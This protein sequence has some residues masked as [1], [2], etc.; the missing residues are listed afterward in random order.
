MINSINFGGLGKPIPKPAPMVA[1]DPVEYKSKI[2]QHIKNVV[3]KQ[4]AE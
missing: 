3:P 4:I 2:E 1:P